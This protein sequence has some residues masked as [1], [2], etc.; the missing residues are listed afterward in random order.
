[1]RT[2]VRYGFEYIAKFPILKSQDRE[3]AA[4]TEIKTSCRSRSRMLRH[5]Y[6]M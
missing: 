6:W 4:N 2:K 1:M 3:S 5:T